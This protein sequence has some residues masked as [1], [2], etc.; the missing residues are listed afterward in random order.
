MSNRIIGRYKAWKAQ[1]P[2]RFDRPWVRR[3]A[4]LE[5]MFID[6]GVLRP[7]WNNPKAFAPGAFRSHHPNRVQLR[8][9]SQRGLKTVVNLRG[10]GVSGPTLFE[11]EA[12]AEAGIDLIGFRMTSRSL[13]TRARLLEFA[14]LVKQSQAPI[15]F[16]C[17]SGADRAGFAAALYMLLQGCDVSKAQAQLSWRYLHF[18]GASTG[19]LDAFLDAYR[20]AYETSG[21]GFMAWLE[22]EYDRDE[23]SRGFQTRGVSTWLVDKV[24]R[25]E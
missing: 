2:E 5:A 6:H 20:Q 10:L 1:W 3:V 4:W 12:C 7:F 23:I 19:L 16:H 8:R 22:T 9:L 18:K 21:V 15:L 14:Q 25:R 11:Q 24:L 17:K 13:P